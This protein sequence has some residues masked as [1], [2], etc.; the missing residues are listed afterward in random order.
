MTPLSPREME[1]L[2]KVPGCG[3]WTAEWVGGIKTRHLFAM[4]W[5]NDAQGCD[6]CLSL[7]VEAIRERD[8]VRFWNTVKHGDPDA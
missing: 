1:E 6:A 5:A 7:L 3:E 8:R 4:D 2:R